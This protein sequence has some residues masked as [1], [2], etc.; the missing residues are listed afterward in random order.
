MPKTK[1]RASAN[2]RR[3]MPT[4]PD[5][6]LTK[7]E[8]AQMFGVTRRWVE[9]AYQRGY[10][11]YVRMGKLVRIRRSDAQAYLEKQRVEVA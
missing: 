1:Q 2:P 6:L 11:P 7:D 10:F 8:V 5:A 3:P 4:D 9:R